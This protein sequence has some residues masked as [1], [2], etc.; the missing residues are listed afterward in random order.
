MHVQDKGILQLALVKQ[1]SFKIQYP[2]NKIFKII[3]NN[4]FQKLKIYEIT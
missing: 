3:K 4:T 2:R 1:K